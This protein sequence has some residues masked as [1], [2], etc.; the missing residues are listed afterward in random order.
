MQY[1]LS[2][3]LEEV[4]YKIVEELPL[5]QQVIFRLSRLEGLCHAE[6]AERLGI[7]VRSVENQIYRALKYIR[8]KLN[9]ESILAE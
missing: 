2:N 7:S 8:E 4:V 1:I 9:K 6:I 5:R 3:D